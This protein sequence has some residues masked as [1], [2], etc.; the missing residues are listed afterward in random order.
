MEWS[1]D[2]LVLG[3]RPF[4]EHSA[5]LET[6]TRNHGRHLGLLRTASS[7]KTRGLLEA[8]NR[9]AV[10]WRARLDE[11]LGNFSIEMASSRAAMFFT[12]GLKLG[13]LASAC[14]VCS[15]TLPE[16]EGHERVY[17]ALDG[18]LQLMTLMPSPDWVPS[19]VR[20][21]VVLLEDLGFGLDLES[22]AVTG[23]KVGLQFVSPKSG[24]AVTLKGAG[25]YANR[26]LA[27]P[28]FLFSQGDVVNSA[29]L[30]S[31]MALTEHFLARVLTESH[32][33]DL[34]ASRRRFSE[35]LSQLA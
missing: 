14:A 2:A 11:Q 22:C 19:Y 12:D 31:G 13:G 23:S 10:Q 34:P 20:F 6:L 18:L 9:L 15:A 16:R 17:S 8:G 33:S 7:K 1:D 35:K 25:A 21:E 24:R 32:G 27:L 29:D 28:G 3:V 4:G 5:I 26:L 30:H